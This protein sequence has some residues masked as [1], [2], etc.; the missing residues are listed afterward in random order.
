MNIINHE[1]TGKNIKYFTPLLNSK[2]EQNISK[3]NLGEGSEVEYI[4]NFLS[5]Q[6][7]NDLMSHLS[8]DIPWTVGTYS[9]F[10]KSVKT[11][12]LLYAMGTN[13][14]PKYKVSN[15]SIW[16]DLVEKLK[17]K[18]EKKYGVT[19]SYCQ[20][21]FYRDKNDHIGYHADKEVESNDSIYSISLGATRRF[22]MK[23]IDET[24]K[25]INRFELESGSLF[26]MNEN[27]AK[28]KYKHRIM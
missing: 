13:V 7:I 5:Q 14:N 16:T 22:D 17:I 12:R 11:P 23:S 9:M 21:N 3:I 24:N 20:M 1:L 18:I 28:I 27:A 6:E 15:Y 19:L 8:N 10:G 4:R 25:T 26:I 2:D